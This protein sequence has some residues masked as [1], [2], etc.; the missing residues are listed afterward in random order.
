MDTSNPTNLAWHIVAKAKSF[1]ASLAGVAGLAALKNSPSYEIYGPVGW[2]PT[3]QSAL[4]LALAHQETEPELDWWGVPGGTAGN[5][6]LQEISDNLTQYLGQEFRIAA[7]PLPYYVE[8]GGIFLKDAAALAGLGIVGANNLLISP[9][10]GPRIR[11]RGLFL[12]LA[13]PSTGP[14]DFAPCDSCPRPCWS[15]CP[16]QAFLSGSYDRPS[17]DQQMRA[18][19]A[20]R[21]P[22]GRADDG[23]LLRVVQYCRACELAC[24]VGR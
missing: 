18:D 15:A 10:Y 16:Q 17:C 23:E 5:R 3:A 6:R 22:L 13:L 14:L 1:G 24:P 2:P 9:A 8:Q 21:V 12:D 19:E 4:V 11:L 20:N 7:Q